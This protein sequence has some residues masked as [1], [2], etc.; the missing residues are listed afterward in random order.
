MPK[1]RNQNE[2]ATTTFTA[3]GSGLNTPV[4]GK[5]SSKIGKSKVELGRDERKPEKRIL[6]LDDAPRHTKGRWAEGE[7]EAAAS[8]LADDY[9]LVDEPLIL[10]ILADYSPDGFYAALPNVQEDLGMLQASAVPDDLDDNFSDYLQVQSSSS[11]SLKSSSQEGGLGLPVA[12]GR[13]ILGSSETSSSISSVWSQSNEA[14]NTPQIISRD[15]GTTAP[16]KRFKTK[17]ARSANQIL[18][19]H[20]S[21]G[22]GK[23]SH[24]AYERQTATIQDSPNQVDNHLEAVAV[25]SPITI[26][27]RPTATRKRSGLD[28]E[29]IHLPHLIDDMPKTLVEVLPEAPPVEIGTGTDTDSYN[30]ESDPE[31]GMT[32][33]DDASG[34]TSFDPMTFLTEVFASIP[35]HQI[36]EVWD[37]AEAGCGDPIEKAI[38]ALLSVEIIRDAQE[39][40][41]W[42]DDEEMEGLG[43]S[44][45][46]RQEKKQD[47]D[48]SADEAK[49]AVKRQTS[50]LKQDTDTSADEAK[51]TVPVKQ[52]VKRQKSPPLGP[53]P[54]DSPLSLAVPLYGKVKAAPAPSA[55]HVALGNTCRISNL[56]VTPRRL[57]VKRKG[58]INLANR[59]ASALHVEETSYVSSGDESAG[60]AKSTSSVS[61]RKRTQL[62]ASPLPAKSVPR[63]SASLQQTTVSAPTST[64]KRESPVA[65]SFRLTSLATHLSSLC[66]NEKATVAH[67]LKYLQSPSYISGFAAMRAALESIAVPRSQVIREIDMFKEISESSD[68]FSF[69]DPKDLELCVRSTAGD[70]AAALDLVSVLKE[71]MLSTSDDLAWASHIHEQ[72]GQKPDITLPTTQ[73][74]NFAHTLGPPSVLPPSP[75]FPVTQKSKRSKRTVEHPQNWRTIDKSLKLKKAGALHPLADFIPAYAK[76]ATPQDSRPGALYTDNEDILNYTMDECRRKALAERQKRQDA[77]RQAGKYFRA[78]VKGNG[79]Q[80]AAFYASQ[81]RAAAE[82]ARLWDLRAARELVEK[83]SSKHDQ[84]CIDI[85]HLTLAEASSVCRERVEAWHASQN[86][87]PTPAKPFR[88]ITGVGK[89]S[90]NHVAILRPG[91]ANVLEGD[92]WRVDR[93]PSERGYIVVRGLKGA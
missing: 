69:L 90:T 85:H 26:L 31:T 73:T 7:M 91:I 23:L 35:R 8:S 72:S 84:F 71:A 48:T 41:T 75:T 63:V 36:Q 49:P 66:R 18:L 30:A 76:G 24:G 52:S 12:N 2:A 40:G 53:K 21:N 27:T 92:G 60:S 6:G 57:E 93:G 19:R 87:I 33:D 82:Q 37:K 42:S 88:I 56:A 59:F 46:V 28:L 64:S 29:S 10:A 5:L 13:P 74:S 44:L 70:V 14:E 4:V 50:P 77:I 43:P 78:N 54:N 61:R 15:F 20:N 68:E 55:N 89:H 3:A 67:F 86:F 83:Q 65:I 1:K 47:T 17:R 34:T 80:V 45:E 39:R 16:V 32:T 79:T 38:E 9:P 25:K 62:D 58:P 11:K 81:A 22:S 51:P